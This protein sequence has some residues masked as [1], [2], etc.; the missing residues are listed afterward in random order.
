VLP[1]VAP[2]ARSAAEPGMFDAM[3]LDVAHP[4]SYLFVE[5]LV[6][7]AAAR[8]ACCLGFRRP[9]SENRIC[10]ALMPFLE[11]ADRFT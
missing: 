10:P 8:L 6:L 2:A 1:A 11:F 9:I 7:I 4:L 5:V 3:R